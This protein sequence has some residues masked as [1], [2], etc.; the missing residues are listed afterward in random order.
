MSATNHILKWEMELYNLALYVRKSMGSRVLF[1]ISYSIISSVLRGKEPKERRSPFPHNSWIIMEPHQSTI[2]KT[3]CKH[4]SPFF[5][6]I[7]PLVMTSVHLNVFLARLNPR[8]S[9]F[10]W[11]NWGIFHVLYYMK[12]NRRQNKPTALLKESPSQLIEKFNK[13]RL[14]VWHAY[15]SL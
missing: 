13:S 11:F 8:T 6:Q 2:V 3:K 14:C 12:K 1:P 15:Y 9:N 5:H 7:Y 10:R 4:F